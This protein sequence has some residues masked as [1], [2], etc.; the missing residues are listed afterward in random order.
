MNRYLSLTIDSLGSELK[1]NIQV[2]DIQGRKR[3]SGANFFFDA[4]DQALW[5]DI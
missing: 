1:D 3:L 4:T 2:K 5:V